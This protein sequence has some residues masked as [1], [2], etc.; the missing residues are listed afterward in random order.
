MKRSGVVCVGVLVESGMVIMYQRIQWIT[1]VEV[2]LSVR[3][4]K[5][6]F[7]RIVEAKGSR[8]RVNKQSA[9]YKHFAYVLGSYLFTYYEYEER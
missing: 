3:L 6:A 2:I 8:V 7:L 4:V 1:F 9:S 5:G